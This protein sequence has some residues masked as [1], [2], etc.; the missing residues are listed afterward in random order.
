[1]LA[2]K[3][4]DCLKPFLRNLNEDSLNLIADVMGLYCERKGLTHPEDRLDSAL[5]LL[6]TDL[7]HLC[8]HTGLLGIEGSIFSHILQNAVRQYNNEVDTH[9]AR[10]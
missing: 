1:M 6:L 8:A 2:S 4:Y 3:P 5:T 7:L 9:S 10:G